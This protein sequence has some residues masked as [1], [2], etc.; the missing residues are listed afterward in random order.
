MRHIQDSHRKWLMVHLNHANTPVVNKLGNGCLVPSS[1]QVN[2]SMVS[3][4][5]FF[6]V[7]TIVMRCYENYIFFFFVNERKEY[8][9]NNF[10][11]EHPP[12]S[13]ATAGPM[14]MGYFMFGLQLH[15]YII[16]I[17]QASV[18]SALCIITAKF[19]LVLHKQREQRVSDSFLLE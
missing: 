8:T 14:I 4:I 15:E 18:L 3:V 17:H 2:G 6:F 16:Q 19:I 11:I 9:I 5:H 1:F 7:F 10:G 13:I 12:Q